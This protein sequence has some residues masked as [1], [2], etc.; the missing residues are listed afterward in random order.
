LLFTTSPLYK[1]ALSP[2]KLPEDGGLVS[3]ATVKEQILYEV[4][5]PARYLTPDVAADFS[6][7]T[8]TEVGPDRVRVAG[9]SHE[10]LT[11]P[12]PLQTRAFELLGVRCG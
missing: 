9:V 12:T 7:V 1:P 6:R 10:Q 2:P 4:H 8:A 5:D 3:E 11:R